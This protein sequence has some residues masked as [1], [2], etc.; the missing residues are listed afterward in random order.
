MIIGLFVIRYSYRRDART[1]FHLCQRHGDWHVYIRVCATCFDKSLIVR[2][3]GTHSDPKIWFQGNP[4]AAARRASEFARAIVSICESDELFWMSVKR[5]GY[6]APRDAL[7]DRLGTIMQDSSSECHPPNA[8]ASFSFTQKLASRKIQFTVP[9]SRGRNGVTSPMNVSLGQRR[10]FFFSLRRKQSYQRCAEMQRI[11]H[12]RAYTCRIA[13]GRWRK[14]RVQ[15]YPFNTRSRY[16]TLRLRIA[17]FRNDI[18]QHSRGCCAGGAM[19][20]A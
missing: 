10:I 1:K 6:F 20:L 14:Q 9:R 17:P 19:S 2:P 4:R 8:W 13:L 3:T 18:T 16:N 11:R 15:K 7:C 5:F 12:A